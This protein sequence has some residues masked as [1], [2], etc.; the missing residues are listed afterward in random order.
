[1]SHTSIGPP[2]FKLDPDTLAYIRHNGEE[3]RES[4]NGLLPNTRDWRYLEARYAID[5]SRFVDNHP[6]I[7]R[8]IAENYRL[9]HEPSIPT[10]P[11]IPVEPPPV[12]Y[13]SVPVGPV[14]PHGVPEPSSAMLCC[15]GLSILVVVAHVVAGKEKS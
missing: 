9:T 14:S 1:M 11:C 3:Y 5:P 2:P 15:I 10:V 12:C 4:H 13:P 7:G 6:L 8:W